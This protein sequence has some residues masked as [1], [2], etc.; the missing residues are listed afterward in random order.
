MAEIYSLK[1]YLWTF[2]LLSRISWLNFVL[3]SGIGPFQVKWTKLVHIKYYFDKMPFHPSIQTLLKGIVR[4]STFW[5]ESFIFTQKLENLSRKSS[6]GSGLGAVLII[7]NLA[8]WKQE[9][10][11]NYV[12]Q[13]Y[14]I[15]DYLPIFVTLFYD[16]ISS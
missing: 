6:D 4:G 16:K 15:L 3:I 14:K 10:F 11:N 9:S 1:S 12:T 2:W 7:L 13:N 8:I 5:Y